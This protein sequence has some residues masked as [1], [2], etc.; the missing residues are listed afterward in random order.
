MRLC[1]GIRYDCDSFDV[2]HWSD[3]WRVTVPLINH[4][5]QQ[6]DAC[7][8]PFYSDVKFIL[9]MLSIA[10]LFVFKIA[11]ACLSALAKDTGSAANE[12]ARTRNDGA[13]TWI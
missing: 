12:R 9:N 6:V 5:N 13:Y 10:A 8:S 7:Y 4:G 3:A 1:F 11:Y 2:V